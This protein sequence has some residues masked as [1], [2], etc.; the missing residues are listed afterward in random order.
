[1]AHVLLVSAFQFGHPEPLVVLVKTNDA[2][3]H[4]FE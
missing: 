2:T 4:R 1:M 3:V